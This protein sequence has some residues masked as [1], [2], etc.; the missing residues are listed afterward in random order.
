MYRANL[1]QV[2]LI[3]FWDLTHIGGGR[4]GDQARALYSSS[5]GFGK[6]YGFMCW[7][8]LTSSDKGKEEKAFSHLT[9]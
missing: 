1:R 7:G 2:L 8:C 9:K 5:S 6:N 3:L 4:K